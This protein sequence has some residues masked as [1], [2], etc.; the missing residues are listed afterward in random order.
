MLDIKYGDQQVLL[1]NEL[2]I[3]DTAQEPS[4]TVIPQ[5]DDY[6]LLMIDPDTKSCHWA[7]SPGSSD[8]PLQAYQKPDSPH[9]YAFL[10]YKQT[11]PLDKQSFNAQQVM[12]NEP[13]KGVNFFTAK[14]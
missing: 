7:M 4:V 3:Q 2:R 8:Q 5:E 14:E 13:L 9:R 6:T 11:E 1:G 12:E 10:L